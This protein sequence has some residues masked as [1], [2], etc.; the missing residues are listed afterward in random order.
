[1][2]DG[3][4]AHRDEGRFARDITSRK[5]DYLFD[6]VALTKDNVWVLRVQ[7]EGHNHEPTLPVAHPIDRKAA[8]TKDVQQRISD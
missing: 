6:A 8:M 7:E 2:C 1:M 5:C 4:K 3:S